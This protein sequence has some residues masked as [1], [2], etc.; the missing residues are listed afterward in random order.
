MHLDCPAH[1]KCDMRKAKTVLVVG[2]IK[3]V[4]VTDLNNNLV[5][6]MQIEI[7]I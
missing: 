2:T 5:P 4:H 6:V 1:L 3:N 7:Q